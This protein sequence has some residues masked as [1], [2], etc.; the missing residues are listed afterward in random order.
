MEGPGGL[1]FQKK[2][3]LCANW[4]EMSLPLLQAVLY[5]E[6]SLSKGQYTRE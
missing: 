1:N 4:Q 2:A 3:F 5:N 6:V